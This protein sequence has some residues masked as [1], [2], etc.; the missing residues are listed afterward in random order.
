MLDQ[1]SRYP[2]LKRL[3]PEP[4]RIIKSPNPGNAHMANCAVRRDLP[5]RP[6]SGGWWRYTTQRR[7]LL[8]WSKQR[9]KFQRPGLP[10][11]TF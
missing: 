1:V 6:S 2:G 7:A 9:P 3:R 8:G 10:Y 4:E 11:Y 5:E